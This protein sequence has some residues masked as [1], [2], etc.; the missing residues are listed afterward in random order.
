MIDA[1]WH[2]IGSTGE[3]ADRT[4]AETGLAVAGLA[5]MSAGRGE[6]KVEGDREQEGRPKG[7][8]QAIDRMDVHA[9]RR[10]MAGL[11]APCPGEEGKR[12]LVEGI[13]GSRI[14]IARQPS[15]DLAAPVVHELARGV[16]LAR[17]APEHVGPGI[18]DEDDELR[19]VRHA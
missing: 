14:E 4:G 18:A 16:A 10:D 19:A 1:A 9:Q 15:D 6:G 5:R 7:M 11:S 13:D 3:G 17:K 8:P 12:R 2:V